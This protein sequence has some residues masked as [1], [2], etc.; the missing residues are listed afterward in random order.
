MSSTETSLATELNQMYPYFE[1]N[2][3]LT[4]QHLNQLRTYLDVQ[5]RLSRVKLVGIGIVCGL[6][7]S[8][9][10]NTITISKGTG[11]TSQGFLVDLEEETYSMS[12]EPTY[13]DP[14]GYAPFLDGTDSVSGQIPMWELITETP[15]EG[16]VVDFSL[17]D[18]SE[19]L[20]DKVVVLFVEYKDTDAQGCIDDCDDKGKSR[21]FTIRRLLLQCS[22]VDR[23]IRGEMINDIMYG[24]DI[25]YDHAS[26]DESLDGSLNIRFKPQFEVMRAFSLIPDETDAE[27][28]VTEYQNYS[29]AA[30][31]NDRYEAFF[32]ANSSDNSLYNLSNKI[33]DAYNYYTLWLSDVVSMS[34][35][36]ALNASFTTMLTNYSS[37]GMMQYYY[38]F[39]KDAV[40]AYNEFIDIAFEIVSECGPYEMMFPRHLVLGKV[41]DGAGCPENEDD[42]KP[43]VYRTHFIQSPIYNQQKDKLNLA[44]SHF[45]RLVNMINN[46][47]DTYSVSDDLK[48][49]P[50]DEKQAEL[51]K[52]SIPFYLDVDPVY[53]NW[54]YQLTKRCI[55]E[56]NLG[57]WMDT[58]SSHEF[59]TEPL[60]FNLDP[61]NFYRI[62]GLLGKSYLDVCRELAILKHQHHL[63]FD[64]LPIKLGRNT[65]DELKAIEAEIVASEELN[66]CDEDKACFTMDIKEEYLQLRNEIIAETEKYNWILTRLIYWMENSSEIISELE[67]DPATA[68]D[69]SNIDSTIEALDFLDEVQNLVDSL[70]KCIEDFDIQEF[71]DAFKEIQEMSFIVSVLF[72]NFLRSLYGVNVL[73]GALF[74]PI[75]QNFIERFMLV[76]YGFIGGIYD[77]NDILR[78]HL[79]VRMQS[80]YFSYLQRLDAIETSRVF[81]NFARLNPGLEH[82]AGVPK[83]GTFIMV[84]GEGTENREVVADFALTGKVCCKPK[85]PFCKENVNPYPPSAKNVY[86]FV[87]ED[88]N[89]GRTYEIDVL[90]FSLDLNVEEIDIVDFPTGSKS[91]KD[92]T[93]TKVDSASLGRSVVQY[94]LSNGFEEGID[95]FEYTIINESGKMDTACVFVGRLPLAANPIHM[96]VQA[97]DQGFN[98]GSSNNGS[99]SNGN[100]SGETEGGTTT[101]AGSAIGG[102]MVGTENEKSWGVEMDGITM[103]ELHSSRVNE[104]ENVAS[105]MIGRTKETYDRLRVRGS[106]N[107]GATAADRKDYEKYVVKE[108]GAVMKETSDSIKAIDLR[109]GETP[110]STKEMLLYRLEFA[111]DIAKRD[112]L[113]SIYDNQS[114]TLAAMVDDEGLAKEKSGAMYKFIDKD[115]RGHHSVVGKHTARVKKNFSKVG[116][117]G[118]MGNDTKALFRSF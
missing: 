44:K 3:M 84:Y 11:I 32:P 37:Q 26:P 60:K 95:R 48:I 74:A 25:P 118:S 16:E 65:L 104:D 43:K 99:G 88:K 71:K 80:V 59:N 22:E 69:Y 91:E 77:L 86:F 98:I 1:P 15:E 19:F 39:A 75:I 13:F 56:R 31:V 85:F 47:R 36:N 18:F 113:L 35:V 51:E 6:E 24:Y 28:F 90:E 66:W 52:R 76:N 49:T 93:I 87:E 58:I 14:M 38:D 105:L 92:T 109:I 96:L 110:T 34:Q 62:E 57:Y 5:D 2:Q 68:A 117:R 20:D 106:L 21:Q 72:E 55:S 54:N 89:E 97:Y 101:G 27:D 116:K 115:V 114:R 73:F 102:A 7:V 53:K 100:D 107:E 78:S 33:L 45:L 50:S 94:S 70:P 81:S 4:S 9:D 42:C 79:D 17:P 30:S 41:K 10:S 29:T 46:P 40:K 63:D 67:S 12:T 108:M 103:A 112:A 64:I 83:G 111:N 23:I 61:Y 8:F 82:M